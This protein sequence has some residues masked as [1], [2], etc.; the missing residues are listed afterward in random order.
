[1]GLACS[2]IT[3][4]TLT[5]LK[6]QKETGIAIEEGHKMALTREMSELSSEYYSTNARPCGDFLV[7]RHEN[8]YTKIG[9]LGAVCRKWNQIY[10]CCR[11]KICDT[12]QRRYFYAGYAALCAVVETECGQGNRGQGRR[13]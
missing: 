13:H 3:L 10:P 9:I 12:S 5:T 6:G 7:F 8:R 1:M 11:L 2:Q 4:L